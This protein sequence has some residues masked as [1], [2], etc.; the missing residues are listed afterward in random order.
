[1]NWTELKF[2]SCDHSNINIVDL[3]NKAIGSS[4]IQLT[5]LLPNLVR[6]VEQF[7]RVDRNWGHK[8]EPALISKT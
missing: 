4:G 6:I 7:D 2:S 5:N 3:K 1:M 8:Y